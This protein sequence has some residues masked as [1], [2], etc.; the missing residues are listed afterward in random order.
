M[1]IQKTQQGG[2][3]LLEHYGHSCIGNWDER[4]QGAGDIPS[5]RECGVSLCL[6]CI[7][8]RNKTGQK[9]LHKS[10]LQKSQHRAECSDG[11]A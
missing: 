7:A 3:E 5:E 6:I 10:R 4:E 9:N 11:L 8:Q 2:R 1:K